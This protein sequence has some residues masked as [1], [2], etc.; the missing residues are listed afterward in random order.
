M[1]R[2]FSGNVK[3]GFEIIAN[4]KSASKNEKNGGLEY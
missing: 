2:E 4:K 1:Y 3:I